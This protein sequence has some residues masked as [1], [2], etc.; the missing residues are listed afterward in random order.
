MQILTQQAMRFVA[1]YLVAT[2]LAVAALLMLTGVIH[3]GSPDYPIWEVMNWFIVFGAPIVLLISIERWR[4]QGEGG[5]RDLGVSLVFY[6]SIVLTII[7]FWQWL[8]TLNPDSEP[9]DAVVSH[10]VHFPLMDSLYR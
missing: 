4:G 7:F 2:G 9:A 6:A 1:A 8:W 10:L 3:D 5:Q